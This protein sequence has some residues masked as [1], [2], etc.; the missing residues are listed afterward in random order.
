MYK[1]I[2]SVVVCLCVLALAFGMFPV[3]ALATPQTHPNNHV[4]TG[5]Q[6]AD[7][8]AVALTQV[9]YCE[10]PGNDTKYG[11]WYGYNYL[12]WCGIFVAWC[13][14][15]AGVPTSVLARTGVSAPEAYGLTVEPD[16]YVPLPGDLFFAR[17]NSHVGLVYYVDG[18]YF[19][20]LEGNTWENGPEGVYIRRHKQSNVKFASPKY[21][22]GGDHNYILGSE[23]AHPH[24]EFYKC[25]HCADQYYTGKTVSRTD[26]TT[27][28]QNSC[29]HSY[30]AYTK[31]SAWQHQRTCNK[32]AKLETGNHSWK[33]SKVLKAATCST[34][35]SKQQ[36]CSLCAAEQTVT[37][38]ATGV[39]SYTKWQKDS[40]QTHTRECTVCGKQESAKHALQSQYQTDENMHWHF[41]D[42]CQEVLDKEKHEFGNSC[43]AP[44]SVCEYKRPEG[45]LYGTQLQYDDKEHWRACEVCK[46]T[47]SVQPHDFSAD[48][49]ETCDTCGYTRSTT[50]QYSDTYLTDETRHYFA[51]T[52]CGQEKDAQNH[53]PEEVERQGAMQHCTVCAAVLTPESLH[54][55]GFDTVFFDAQQHWGTCSCG[56]E[57]KAEHHRWSVRTENCSICSQAMPTT[58]AD[59]TDLI[60]WVA[61]TAGI[62]V[63]GIFLM[64]LLL[65]KRK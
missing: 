63:V 57:M 46:Q 15:Q 33:D 49:D 56:L 21:K 44:C 58:E 16:G 26:C 59:N 8:V 35:G 31:V 19:Y 42:G 5:D 17:D 11:V 43:D 29:S 9:G 45:H 22:G 47:D 37:I 36:K 6:R 39:H 51:C 13:A 18:E 24:K 2:R 34:A 41:C 7:I 12:A 28:V 53:V 25:T 54:T 10:G 61:G 64:F 30:S 27:C 50:H 62:L 60:P 23:T 32:C 14:N 40:E 20:S 55:H 3:E 4:N 38:S 52:V 1:T 65:R 48:C